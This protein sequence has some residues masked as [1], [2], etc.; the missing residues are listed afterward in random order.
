[1]RCSLKPLLLVPI[2]SL[3]FV[4]SAS[5]AED[6]MAGATVEEMLIQGEEFYN[7]PVSCWVC[8]G[9][10]AE[11]R[12]G[13]SLH[14]GPDAATIWEQIQ[15]N[16]QMGIIAS[17]LNPTDD[18]LVAVSIYIRKMA[19]LPV[20]QAIIDEQTMA[21]ARLKSVQV[22][23]IESV[24]TPRDLE[25]QRVESFQSVLDDWQ[26]KAKTGSLKRSY[27]SRV[28]ATF[29][30]GEA[31][32]KPEAG[33]TYWYENIGNSSNPTVLPEGFSNSKS[34]QVVVGD[35][36]TKE[37]IAH[38]MIP[39]ELRAAVHTTAMSPDGKFVYIIG[40]QESGAYEKESLHK[41]SATVL[42]VDALDFTAGQTVHHRWS[43]S[44]R[45]DIPGPLHAV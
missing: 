45:S 29:E 19:G 17:E 10:K 42:K 4:A 39:T 35:A 15:S 28:V 41:T 14:N 38:Y 43:L 30:P 27:E 23:E 6:P 8:H 36:E 44:P 20:S 37:V 2:L 33:K 5:A 7:K 1:M 34:S 3:G 22:D 12:V 25:V 11:G 31:L 24:L 9:E 16:P 32:F 26:R 21:L 13:P 40:S 18:D